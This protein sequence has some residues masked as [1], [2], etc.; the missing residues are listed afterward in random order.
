MLP[1]LRQSRYSSA[2]P[3]PLR[4]RGV[5][6]RVGV[7]APSGSSTATLAEFDAFQKDLV[8]RCR[9][10]EKTPEGQLRCDMADLQNPE[11]VLAACYSLAK[12]DAKMI[13]ECDSLK[14][15]LADLAAARAEAQ[16]GGGDG[17]GMLLVGLAAAVGAFFLLRK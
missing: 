16:S 2:M 5:R 15:P 10:A 13:K 11:K 6:A 9:K 12:G 4:P 17:S 14:G 1:P 7:V 8:E 3:T